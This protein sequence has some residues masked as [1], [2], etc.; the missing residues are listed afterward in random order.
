MEKKK[1]EKEARYFQTHK[2]EMAATV[3]HPD[4]AMPWH[5]FNLIILQNARGATEFVDLCQHMCVAHESILLTKKL[6]EKMNAHTTEIRLLTNFSSR[7]PRQKTRSALY[8]SRSSRHMHHSL[9]RTIIL[10][11]G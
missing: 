8:G 4:V 11:A 2:K 9:L 7:T 6:R 3:G 10:I 1:K 5:D